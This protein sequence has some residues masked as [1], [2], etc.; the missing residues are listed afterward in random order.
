MAAL[1]LLLVAAPVLTA[2]WLIA[3]AIETK[4]QVA[5]LTRRLNRLELELLELRERWNRQGQPAARPAAN[6][7]ETPPALAAPPVVL[8]A[9]VKA[10]VSAPPPLPMIPPLVRPVAPSPVEAVPEPVA[11]A[12]STAS[13][14]EMTEETGSGDAGAEAAATVERGG[15]FE[16]RLGMF[17]LV[18]VGVVM[19]LTGLVFFGNYAWHNFVGLLGPGGKLSLLY[20]ASAALL[21]AGLWWQRR[22][23]NESMRNYAQVLFAGGLAA[24]YFTTYAAHHLPQLCVINSATLDGAL[25]LGWTAFMAW[26]ADRRKSEVLALFA[27]GLAYYAAVITE[28]GP[29]TLYSNLLLTAAGVFF[30]VRHRWAGLSL[31]CLVATYASYAF[32]RFYHPDGWGWARPGES[33]WSGAN[34]L[35]AYWVLFTAAA[36]LSRAPKLAGA[37]RAA[38][39]TANNAAFFTLF[40]LTMLQTQSGGLW[41][42]CLLLGAGLLALSLAARR[43]LAAEPLLANTYLTQGI[44]LVTVGLVIKYAGLHLALIL[45]FESVALFMSGTLDRSRV[46]IIGA[47]IIGGMAVA[48]CGL[49]LYRS[50]PNGNWLGAAV[51]AFMLLSA[52]WSHRQRPQPEGLPFRPEPGYFTLL[53]L[54]AW[55]TATWFGTS[56]DNFPLV[57]AAETAVLTFSIYLLGVPEITL[58]GQGLLLVAQMF[59]IGRSASLFA[60]AFSWKPLLLIGVTLGLGHWWQ[61]QKTLVIARAASHFWQVLYSLALV[62]VLY[63][64]LQPQSSPQA[65]LAL[66]SLLA[67]AVTAYGLITRAWWLAAAGQLLLAAGIVQFAVQLSNGKPDWWL[68]LAPVATLAAL[69]AAAVAWTSDAKHQEHPARGPLLQAAVIYRWTALVMAIVWVFVY[70]PDRERIWV[71]LGL[72]LLAFAIAG[73]WRLREALGFSAVLTGMGL[74]LTLPF[75][76]PDQFIYLPTLLALLAFLGQQQIA[77]RLPGRYA[78]AESA[79]T[80]VIIAGCIDLW[81]YVSRAIWDA[82]GGSY[83]TASWAAYA[84]ILFVCGMLLSE[85]VYRW[86]GLGILAAS[87]GRVVL[88]DVWKQEPIYRV[89]TFLALGIVLLLLGFIYNRYQEQIRKWL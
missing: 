53:A 55:L 50:E 25:L 15:S 34:F 86:T 16:M 19:L 71:L 54:A 58:A 66:T 2:I 65:W 36:F 26:I 51:G 1:I 85:R 80:A 39:A 35:P 21:G 6:Q 59:W 88:L 10:P 32:W 4:G 56:A 77:R 60:T 30:L 74:I 31:A 9:E 52:V 47:Y 20:A 17:W 81:W 28:V 33:L 61:R 5:S 67:V 3:G 70:I 63:L 27:V 7:A 84:L 83:L 69:A 73:W 75:L 79:H 24:V 8:A 29:F 45:G 41:K 18:R 57:L 64:W 89:L 68:P 46:Q 82:G 78:R 14:P 38:Y 72:G 22:V 12:A 23:E 11:M 48:W 62:A 42:F 40:L 43:W 13:V 87:V 37:N 44:L 49:G 76:A